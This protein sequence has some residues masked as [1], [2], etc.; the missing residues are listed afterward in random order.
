MITSARLCILVTL[1]ALIVP[2]RRDISAAQPSSTT[3]GINDISALI[4]QLADESDDL[5][6][7]AAYA[8]GRH[9]KNAEGAVEALLPLLK[10]RYR[11]VRWYTAEALGRLGPQAKQA[12]GPLAAALDDSDS[13]RFM[14]RAAAEA[15]GRIGADAKPAVEKLV[16][17][18]DNDDHGLRVVAAVALWRIERY[19]HSAAVLLE[20][21]AEGTGDGPFEAA[22]A[23]A[24]HKLAAPNRSTVLIAALSHKRADV[25]RAAAKAL[26]SLGDDA[27]SAIAKRTADS[28]PEVQLAA[29]SA[30]GFLADSR[31]EKVFYHE[32]T[33]KKTVQRR[34]PRFFDGQTG[35][36]FAIERSFDVRS[37]SRGDFAR[38]AWAHRSAGA[39]DLAAIG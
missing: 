37:A 19:Q 11:E 2:V 5:R 3:A 6:R 21:I 36:D 22:R 28:D 33:T 30:L 14:Q 9:G 16:V 18:L 1:C 4:A 39:P 8:L 35:I 38:Q 25:R 20:T 32:T 31:R 7:Q 23:V 24:R 26:G 17:L 29:L 34:R 12:V 27:I 13:D 10:D 15:L